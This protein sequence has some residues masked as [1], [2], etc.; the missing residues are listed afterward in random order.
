MLVITLERRYACRDG[1]DW[2]FTDGS[3]TLLGMATIAIDRHFKH[4]GDANPYDPQDVPYFS[5][6]RRRQRK[7]DSSG[8]TSMACLVNRLSVH[9]VECR[10]LH[11]TLPRLEPC[12]VKVALTVRRGRGGGNAIPLP[13]WVV[14]DH[15]ELPLTNKEAE[16]ALRHWVIAQRIAMGTRTAQGTRAFALLASVIETYRKRA[17]SPWTYLDLAAGI[18][19][20]HK[21]LPAPP[22]PLPAT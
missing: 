11:G 2:V 14:L 4:R 5:E 16:R 10:V 8:P 18:R 15:P 9:L 12:S 1:L 13:D 6:R 3:A 7:R 19:Q 22:L 20:R 17:A 21:G